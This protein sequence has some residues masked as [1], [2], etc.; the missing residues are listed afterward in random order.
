[1]ISAI[2]YLTLDRLVCWTLVNGKLLKPHTFV[3][4]GLARKVT[5]KI[6]AFIIK[7]YLGKDLKSVTKNVAMYLTPI[8]N[9]RV[10]H[11]PICQNKQ[12]IYFL[13]T[14]ESGKFQDPPPPFCVDVMNGWPLN[15]SWLWRANIW[16]NNHIHVFNIL[17]NFLRKNRKS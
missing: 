5:L 11:S 7:S 3:K 2:N 14:K 1:M 4:P 15:S 16:N 12:W 13:K 17:S 10:S 8:Q 6:S 9:G